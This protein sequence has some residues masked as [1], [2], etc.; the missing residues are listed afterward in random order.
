[1]LFVVEQRVPDRK[2][3]LAKILLQLL[4]ANGGVIG[5]GSTGESTEE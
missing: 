2:A 5:A 3:I 1:L 4:L